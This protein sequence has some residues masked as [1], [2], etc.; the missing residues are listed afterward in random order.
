MGLERM[1]RVGK[2]SGQIYMKWTLETDKTTPRYI[3]HEETK[4]W[5]MA[6]QFGKRA[7]KYEH[8]MIESEPGTMYREGIKSMTKP[9]T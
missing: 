6:T 7:M 3:L 5:K 8:K 2:D 1:E 9:G 4:R